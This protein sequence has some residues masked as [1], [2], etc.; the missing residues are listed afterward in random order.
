MLRWSGNKPYPITFDL[1]CE[2]L[3][4]R[5][6]VA[7][8]FTLSGQPASGRQLL[9][10]PQVSHDSAL[11]CSQVDCRVPVGSCGL[12][13]N[14]CVASLPTSALTRRPRYKASEEVLSGA[15]FQVAQ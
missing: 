15:V 9:P 8:E 3:V 6:E 2:L 1:N 14:V 13:D 4:E 10:R 7:C 12:I 5:I 11:D